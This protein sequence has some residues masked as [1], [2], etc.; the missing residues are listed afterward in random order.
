MFCL[1][2]ETKYQE[3]V[4]T[5]DSIIRSFLQALSSLVKQIKENRRR[6]TCSNGKYYHYRI[7]IGDSGRT[8]PVWR[9]MHCMKLYYNGP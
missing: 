9:P 3:E 5:V 7:L 4:R 2:R 8:T 1:M 6:M